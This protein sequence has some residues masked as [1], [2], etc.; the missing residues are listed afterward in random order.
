MRTIR[1]PGTGV[2]VKDNRP[3]SAEGAKKGEGEAVK[4]ETESEKRAEEKKG[5]A[6]N[7]Q[8][9]E[10][11]LKE[12][13]EK[14]YENYLALRQMIAEKKEPTAQEKERA[15]SEF[16][17]LIVE[18]FEQGRKI[19]QASQEGRTNFLSKTVE[20]WRSFFD[21]FLHRTVKKSA[22]LAEIQEFLFR[23]LVKKNDAKSVLI[24]D[25]ILNSGKTDKF[26]R[27]AVM[28]QNLSDML[29][30]LMPGDRLAAQSLADGLMADTLMYLAINPV[31][32]EAE[33]LTGMQP[34]QGMFG[35]EAM[36]ARVAEELGISQ[37]KGGPSQAQRGML[38]RGKKK[39]SG[40]L[41]WMFGDEEAPVDDS[42]QFIPA[43]QW[44]TLKRPGLNLK[45]A[46]YSGVFIIFVLLI[47]FIIDRLLAK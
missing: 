28:H 8:I 7:M 37:D 16:E 36:E 2:V 47:I 13:K 40:M 42:G 9:K 35:A 30:K 43:W 34:R 10:G 39:R 4:G 32:G 45:R 3:E 6:G 41:G 25:I 19:E 17:R 33:I 20:Q 1:I 31:G 46:F 11:V 5:G 23:G 27:F 12:V 21:K 44:G 26:A 15:L 14:T 29:S 38:A 18:R 24:S 22:E